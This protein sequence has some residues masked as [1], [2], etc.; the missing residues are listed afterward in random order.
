MLMT[1]AILN[2]QSQ[3][4][5]DC[6][7]RVFE[8]GKGMGL[9]INPDKTKIL[10]HN[11]PQLTH[12][13]LST[14]GTIAPSFTH[15]GVEISFNKGLSYT[16]T[17]K[18]ALRRMITTSNRFT[19]VFSNNY[20]YK[21]MLVKSLLHSIFHHMTSVLR[22]MDQIS[23][24]T[25]GVKDHF[26]AT[27]KA[28]EMDKSYVLDIPLSSSIHSTVSPSDQMIQSI[29]FPR[30]LRSVL[31]QSTHGYTTPPPP[32]PPQALTWSHS[33]PH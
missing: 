30:T 25:T 3:F 29:P 24:P 32:L 20:L 23:K 17:Y 16:R 27:L 11:S 14:I 8:I 26:R 22:L 21:S 2:I 12:E 10:V 4:H 33:D 5:L 13:M 1:L 18:T 28:F 19:R 31:K 9:V 7:L 6:L 15:L